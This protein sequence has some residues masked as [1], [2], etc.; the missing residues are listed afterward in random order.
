[1]TKCPS[2]CMHPCQLACAA[3]VMSP[4]APRPPVRHPTGKLAK[5]TFSPASKG[6]NPPPVNAADN[7]TATISISVASTASALSP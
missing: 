2:P 5:R 6:R 3:L 7:I 1:M 4:C